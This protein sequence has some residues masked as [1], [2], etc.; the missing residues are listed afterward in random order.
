MPKVHVVIV[1]EAKAHAAH[2]HAYRLHPHLQKALQPRP[3]GTIHTEADTDCPEGLPNCRHCG[4]QA[5]ADACRA[6]GHCPDCGTKH[7]VAPESVIAANG[8]ALVAVKG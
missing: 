2:R 8:Y 5:H 1:D 3:V 4:D 6:A 7:G